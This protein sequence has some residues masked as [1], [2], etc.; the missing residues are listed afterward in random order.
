MRQLLCKNVISRFGLTSIIFLA[1]LAVA[2]PAMAGGGGSHIITLSPDS[3]PSGMVGTAY[4]E[5]I[6]ASDN[7]GDETPPLLNADDIF[8][9]SVTSGSLPPGL[10]LNAS[11]GEVGGTPTAGGSFT[12]TVTASNPI[13][14]SG[15]K[16]YTIYCSSNSLTLNPATL[17]NGFLGT[18]YSQTVTASGGVGPYTYTILSGSL[19]VGL[20]LNAS[21]GVISGTPTG[22]G[23]SSFTVHALDSV[24]NTGSQN[25]TVYI[26]SNSLA[27]T[28]P[29]LPNGTQGTAY[30]QTVT[31]SG[32]TGPYTYTISSG[33]LPVGL[34]LNASTG[35]IAGTP[36]GSGASS[37]TVHALDSVGNTGSQ[38]YTVYISSNSLAI[39]PPTLPNGTQGTAYSQT[40]T[41]SGGTGPY[42]YT[43]SSGSLPAGL[44]LNASTGVISGT[45][46]GSGASSF[47]VHALDSVG[48]TGSQNYT[49]YISSNSLAIAPPT[50]P[51]GTQGVAYSQTVTASGGVGP[52]TYTI[53]SGSLPAGLTL[54]AST[55]VIAGTPSGSGASS[56]T[57]HALDS[58]GNTGA[59]NYTVYISSNSLA[60]T[61]PT[62]PN[63]M[64]G[65]AYSQTVTASGGTGPYTY[66][67]SSGSLPAGLT[68]NASTG[69]IA[70]TPSGS[71]ASSFTVHALDSVGN[72]GSQNYTVYISSNSLAITPP[73]LPNGTQGM[74]YSQTVSASGGTG[75][76][77]YT[78][79]S[80][81]LPAGLTLNASTG[82]IA[83]TP[84]G[85][86]ASSFHRPRAR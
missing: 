6:S 39:T 77:T 52:Y 28:P 80:G 81:S 76:Y 79:S 41:A 64:Q 58:V 29:T 35:V 10:T 11:T 67:I 23:A 8:S 78:I 20:T 27:I 86:G 65:A 30:S 54:N 33:S 84:S 26:S 47:T 45:P 40:V 1:A 21:T 38:N 18:A 3:L 24:G 56:F 15:S 9:F 25:Y 83:G 44:T 53:S 73:T 62:L 48:N 5:T 19:P 69:V 2:R 50:L 74:A 82:V 72:T 17:P 46:S 22:S 60:I 16:T 36:S 71:G 14:G 55:G 42:T 85:S 57:V 70:G 66:T 43:I 32:G 51:N 13:S 75:P 61:P 59:Q 68:L 49:V 34:T 63:G 7:D 4:S 12:F 37:F 31:A